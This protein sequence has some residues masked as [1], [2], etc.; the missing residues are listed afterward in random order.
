MGNFLK[1]MPSPLIYTVSVFLEKSFSLITIPLMAAYLSPS[2]YGRFDIAISFIEFVGIIAGLGVAS[3]LI[4]FG[5]T[6][7][8]EAGTKQCAREL[9]GNS[10]LAA[11]LLSVI[12]VIFARPMVDALLIEIGALALYA[13]LLSACITSLV[14]LPLMWLRLKDDAV[15]FMYLVVG[16]TALQVL[17]MWIA[18][19]SGAGYE[20]VMVANAIVLIGFAAL[21]AVVQ[22]AETGVAFSTDRLREM[23]RYGAPIVGA[24]LATYALGT[25][26]RLFMPTHVSD[27][28]VGYYGLATRLSLASFLLLHPFALWWIPRRI[29]D[30]KRPNGPRMVA[31]AWGLGF[32]ILLFSA[33]GVALF[34]PVLVKWFLPAPYLAAI[35]LL[36][37]TLLAQC[38]HTTVFLV[39]TGTYARRTSYRVL[40]F[41]ATAAAIAV[42][43]FYLFIP[44]YGVY[45][46]IG[47]IIACQIF[48]LA[49]YWIDGNLETPVPY[50]WARALVGVAGL[51]ALTATAPSVDNP[52]LRTVWTAAAALALTGLL[53]AIKLAP[54]PP[55]VLRFL[56]SAWRFV[57]GAAG[58]P[59][60]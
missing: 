50:P 29:A 39:S 23:L 19:S 13:Q 44:I 48:R 34:G 26:N 42:L 40:L 59:K 55:A 58:R 47:S 28:V 54:L 3:Q 22:A 25:A 1:R 38:L 46:A 16:R 24:G 56:A 33:L 35:T 2:E 20:G 8:D 4:R 9:L 30:L 52:I 27:E 41:D 43:G 5:S 49:A 57:G 15:N 11:L 18:L 53:V 14:D 10:L 45:G 32:S 51:V 12:A 60:D 31:D 21:L 7:V 6:A 17:A 36:P 37:L